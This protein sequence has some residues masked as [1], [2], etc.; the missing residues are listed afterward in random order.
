MK[1][2]TRC[3]VQGSQA[4]SASPLLRLSV[5]GIMLLGSVMPHKSASQFIG[6]MPDNHWWTLSNLNLSVPDSYCYHDSV[7]NGEKYGRLY[8]W[9][10]AEKG[11]SLLGEGWHLPSTEE[12]N[13]LLKHFG[14]AFEE[15]ISDGKS[16][17]E[18]L[19]GAE[20]S[21]FGATSGGNRNP[22]GTY[23]RMEAHGFYWTSTSFDEGS[24][25]FLNFAQHRKVLFLQPDMEKGRAISVRCI[26]NDP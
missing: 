11:C 14:G 26:R 12:W 21:T 10:A 1:C 22:D 5:V 20:K 17:F 24:A 19:W 4:T 25:G 3:P 23:S 2:T 16:A 6:K 13:A 18:L 7:R 8:T 15:S 9:E